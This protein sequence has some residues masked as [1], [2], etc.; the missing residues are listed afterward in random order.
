MAD[1]PLAASSVPKKSGGIAQP[2]GFLIEFR[3]IALLVNRSCGSRPDSCGHH[4]GD[5]VLQECAQL[6]IFLQ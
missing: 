3:S 4:S 1:W 5:V 6:P 2:V